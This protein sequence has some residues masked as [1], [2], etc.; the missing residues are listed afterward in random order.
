MLHIFYVFFLIWCHLE[1]IIRQSVEL[2]EEL[3]PNERKRKRKR[4]TWTDQ[5][6]PNAWQW[7]VNTV[8]MPIELWAP[9]IGHGQFQSFSNW[10]MG[11][12]LPLAKCLFISPLDPPPSPRPSPTAKSSFSLLNSSFLAII[13]APVPFLF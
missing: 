5:V 13:I 11:E 8:R 1:S 4:Q 6:L 10:G 7:F 9:G 12:S 2:L 3:V